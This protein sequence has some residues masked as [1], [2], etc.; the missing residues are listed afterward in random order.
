MKRSKTSVLGAKISLNVLIIEA[1]VFILLTFC[2]VSAVSVLIRNVVEEN[3]QTAAVDR[4]QIIENYIDSTKD[5]LTAYLKAGEIYDLLSDPKSAEYVSKAQKYTEEF[6]KDISYLEGI[7]ASSWDTKMLTHTNSQVVGKVTRPDADRLKALHD[8]LDA[9]GDGVYN[10]GMIISPASGEQIISM[11]KAVRDKNGDPIGLGGIGIY[12][13]GLV[14]V[15]DNLPIQG[16]PSAR[17]YLVNVGSGEYIFHPDSEKIMTAAE[18]AYV[19]DII[20]KVNGGETS[21]CLTYKDNGEKYIA[22][23]N[24]MSSEGW[25]FIVSDGSAEALKSVSVVRKNVAFLFLI[26]AFAVSTLLYNAIRKLMKPLGN[27]EAAVC[28]A[29]DIHFDAANDIEGYIGRNDEIGSMAAAVNNLCISMKNASN[30]IGRILGEM[31]DENF[32]VDVDL[33]KDIYKGD[34]SVL[35]GYIK[36]IRDK[37]TDV[38][39][40]IYEASDQVNSG[41]LQVA[42]GA[43]ALSS[44]ASEQS[45]SVDELVNRLGDIENQ[46]QSNSESC[47]K[48]RE[49]MN[50]TSAYVD[51]VSRKMETLTEAMSDINGSSAKISNIIKTIEDIAFQTNILALNAAVE[52]ARAGAAGKGFAV[53]ADEVRNLAAKSAEAVSDTTKLIEGSIEAVNNG[54]AITEQTNSAMQTLDEYT[55]AVRDIVDSIAGS[56]EKQAEMV[57]KINEDVRRISGVVQA[58]SATAEE[59]AAASEELSGQAD[60]LKELIGKFTLK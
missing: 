16:L 9:A 26:S 8:S 34:F 57:A 44:G 4:S 25:I 28:S 43:Q 14:S 36:T 42:Q 50:K 10:T 53:V 31:A 40:N 22:A 7:Y 24:S 27:I 33:N 49:L 52:A 32:A 48:A 12:S 21:G 46:V 15:L 1:L 45:A 38:L 39:S 41:S 2:I 23:F 54:A 5:T 58:N 35:F 60:T 6:S 30:D 59:S 51:E 47:V 3:M 37:L 55:A 29:A 18:E 13:S 56:G 17:Y 20:S 19:A 11:Y